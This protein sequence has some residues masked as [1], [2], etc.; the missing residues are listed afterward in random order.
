MLELALDE[1][2]SSLREL[3]VKYTDDSVYF[4]SE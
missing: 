3:A 1:T 2:E 4:V